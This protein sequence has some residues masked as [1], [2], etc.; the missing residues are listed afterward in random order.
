VNR[1]KSFESSRLEKRRQPSAGS[2]KARRRIE[3]SDIPETDFSGAIRGLFYRPV[4]EAISLRIDADILAWQRS[5]GDGYQS[6]INEIL[7]EAM[8]RSRRPGRRSG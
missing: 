3:L 8:M 5:M 1:K 2:T 7:R 4:K 6:R